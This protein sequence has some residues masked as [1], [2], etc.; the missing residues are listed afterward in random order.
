MISP[1]I[2]AVLYSFRL[3]VYADPARHESVSRRKRDVDQENICFVNLNL[4]S[5]TDNILSASYVMF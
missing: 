3:K 1:G 4:I 2:L 5:T